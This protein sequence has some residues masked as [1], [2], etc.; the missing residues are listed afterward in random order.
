MRAK[1]K[2]MNLDLARELRKLWKMRVMVIPIATS[3]FGT[4]PNNTENGL[5]ELEIE[6]RINNIQI[7]AL[8]GPARIL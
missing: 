6:L 1:N 5:E 3:A 8:V 7:T 2:D 4:V